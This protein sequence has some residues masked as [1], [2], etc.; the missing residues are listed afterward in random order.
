[1]WEAFPLTGDQL[2]RLDTF[3]VEI[4]DLPAGM[5]GEVSGD[6]VYIDSDAADY[7]W[8]IDASTFENSAI[9]ALLGNNVFAL[10]IEHEDISLL[11]ELHE[12]VI[13]DPRV[14]DSA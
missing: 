4:A 6:T 11:P 1:L 3:S 5:L 2:D 9:A 12:I 13:A 7:G 8:F 14:P 10:Q